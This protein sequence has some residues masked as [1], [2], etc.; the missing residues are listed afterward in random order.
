MH[1]LPALLIL[2]LTWA[3]Q[4]PLSFGYAYSKFALEQLT[5]AWQREYEAKR[6]RF[7]L[8]VPGRVLTDGFPARGSLDFVGQTREYSAY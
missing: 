6:V 5:F 2:T 7:N 1:V 4:E 8:L 3:R